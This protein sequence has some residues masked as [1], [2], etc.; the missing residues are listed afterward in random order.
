MYSESKKMSNESINFQSLTVLLARKRTNEAQF[1]A[2][3]LLILVSIILIRQS[4]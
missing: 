4:A 2:T 3:H 1:A